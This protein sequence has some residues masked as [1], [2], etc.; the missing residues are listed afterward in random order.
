LK[1]TDPEAKDLV[2][3]D[4]VPSDEYYELNPEDLAYLTNLWE[5]H[6]LPAYQQ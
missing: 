1:S 3:L 4:I 2:A 5:S 6:S